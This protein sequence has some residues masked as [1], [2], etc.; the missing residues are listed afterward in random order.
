MLRL[1]P[2]TLEETV[3]VKHIVQGLLDLRFGGRYDTNEEMLSSF[4]IY[5]FFLRRR[6]WFIF[7]LMTKNVGRFLFGFAD[8]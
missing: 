2:Q 7:T 1:I 3:Q 8:R 5:N 6:L 4:Y